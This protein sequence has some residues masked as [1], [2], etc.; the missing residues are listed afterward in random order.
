MIHAPTGQR[1]MVNAVDTL[2]VLH[3]LE[4]VA[5]VEGVVTIQGDDDAPE[6]GI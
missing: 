5:A 4:Q 6:R 2:E 3:N 1:K